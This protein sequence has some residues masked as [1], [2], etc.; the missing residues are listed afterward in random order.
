MAYFI[1]GALLQNQM[2]LGVQA[3]MTKANKPFLMLSVADS[4]GNANQ[5]SCS[6]PDAMAIIRTLRQGDHVD[7][8]LVIA[9]GPNKQ[10]AMVQ[11]GGDSV[12]VAQRDS[13]GY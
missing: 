6:D 3:R 7:L 13:L 12:L 4:E 11:R 8:R 10:Y 9:G 2:V 5:F 1:S